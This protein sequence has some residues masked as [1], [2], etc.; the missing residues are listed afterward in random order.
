MSCEWSNE[1]PHR[2]DGGNESVDE[3]PQRRELTDELDHATDADQTQE[4][5]RRHLCMRTHDCTRKNA[6]MWRR[7]VSF[8][9]DNI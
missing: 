3:N 2:D 8:Q 1:N 5:D 4:V 7:L 9:R 6:H